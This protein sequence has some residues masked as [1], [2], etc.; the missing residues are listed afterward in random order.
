MIRA[1]FKHFLSFWRETQPTEVSIP[2]RSANT[3]S[4]VAF[5]QSI[6]TAQ[7]QMQDAVENGTL[8]SRMNECTLVHRFVPID[9]KYKCAVYA[10]EIF[11]P[12]G[13]VVIGK[14]HRHAHLNFLLEGSVSV[15]TEFGK[16][17][18]EAPC[19]FVSQPGLKRAVVAET[20]VRWTTVHLTSHQSEARLEEIE[21]EVISPTYEELGLACSFNGLARIGGS[22]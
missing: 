4:K 21:H 19:T 1:L 18:M 17:H 5:R 9:E 12:K 11:I 20:D 14:I 10:R 2:H 3:L 13:T 15:N 22:K 16:Q 8:Q 6:L 7:Q